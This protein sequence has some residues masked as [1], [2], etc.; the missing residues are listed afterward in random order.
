MELDLGPPLAPC[1]VCAPSGETRSAAL[2]PLFH[3]ELCY[4]QSPGLCACVCVVC[5]LYNMQT[6]FRRVFN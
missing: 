3:V 6:S 1:S 2:V 4:V 5:V